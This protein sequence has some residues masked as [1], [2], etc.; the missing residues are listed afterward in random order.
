MNKYTLDLKD[1]QDLERI[2]DLLNTYY[3]IMTILNE[4]SEHSIEG[5]ASCHYVVEIKFKEEWV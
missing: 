2:K 1:K 5:G 3:N 4:D